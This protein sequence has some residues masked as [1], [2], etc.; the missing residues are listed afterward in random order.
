NLNSLTLNGPTI[1]GTPSNLASTQYS[2]LLFGGNQP[3]VNI[4]SSILHLNSLTIGNTNT[5]GVTQN[6]NI[7]LYQSTAG[8]LTLNSSSRLFLG[9]NN[10]TIL[11]NSYSATISGSF[12]AS[13][14]VVADGSGRLRKNFGTSGFAAFT[15]PIGDNS[16]GMGNNP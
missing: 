8:V 11:S 9:S 10:L 15:F 1:A 5:D 4:P 6:S 13:T 12:S 14:M 3:V 16:G 2:N 7:D